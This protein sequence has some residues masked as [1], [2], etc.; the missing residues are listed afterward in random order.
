[1]FETVDYLFEE[2]DG[3]IQVCSMKTAEPSAQGTKAVRKG[4][5][6]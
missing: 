3:K 5:V 1:M 2:R 4:Y 6:M